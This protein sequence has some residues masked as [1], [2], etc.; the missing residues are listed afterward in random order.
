MHTHHRPNTRIAVI[1]IFFLPP[2]TAT[3]RASIGPTVENV[4]P[5]S[6]AVSLGEAPARNVPTAA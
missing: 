2:A 4:R 1:A 5:C 6:V 3:A